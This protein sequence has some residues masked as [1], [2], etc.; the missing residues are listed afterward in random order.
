MSDS[1]KNSSAESNSRIRDRLAIPLGVCIA[2]LVAFLSGV[3]FVTSEKPIN[4]AR[5]PSMGEGLNSEQQAVAVGRDYY[6]SLSLVEVSERN[7]SGEVW[8]SINESGPDITVEI[9]WKG[10]RIYRSTTKED[11]FVAKWST[12]EIHLGQM[13]LS[14]GTT[15]LDDLV[16]AAR[17]NIRTDELITIKVIDADL[18]S[19]NLIGEKTFTTTDLAVG[20]RSYSFE[21][22]GII[23]LTIRVNDMQDAIDILR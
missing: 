19:Q 4:Q 22:P 10:N 8:D 18:L 21:G 1:H 9:Y 12:G 11:T 3:Y 16:Q 6:I 20:E 5:Q 2:A 13:A 17:L 7:P 23:R 15:S 14:G